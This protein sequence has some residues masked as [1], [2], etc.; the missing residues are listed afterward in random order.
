MSAFDEALSNLLTGRPPSDLEGIAAV[1]GT[2]PRTQNPAMARELAGIGPGPLPFR[3]TAQRRQY[4]AALRNLQRYRAPAGREHRT[5]RPATLGRLREGAGRILTARNIARARRGGLMMRLSARI[6]VS[7]KWQTSN[8][9]SDVGGHP[10]YQFIPGATLADTL[11]RWA[12]GD[13]DAAG[14]A[15]L[16]A[17]FTAYWGTPN[18]A[19][20]GQ[21]E[22]V[23]LR[24]PTGPESA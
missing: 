18:P 17:F 5:P 14:A 10:R 2:E 9:P 21:I 8:M 12:A 13:L 6:R 19:D 3:G 11:A 24:W 7:R 23:R 16:A 22:S 20:V 4:A 1:Y 15:L